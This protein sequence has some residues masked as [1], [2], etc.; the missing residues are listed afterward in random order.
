VPHDIDVR[1]RRGRLTVY[2]LPAI[3]RAC[4]ETGAA[5]A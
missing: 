3:P 2:A 5:T 4:S 1:G